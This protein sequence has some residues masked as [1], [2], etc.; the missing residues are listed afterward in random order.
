[1][2]YLSGYGCGFLARLGVVH[3][4]HGRRA[5]PLRVDGR[6]CVRLGLRASR[7]A[8]GSVCGFGILAAMVVAFARAWVWFT[9]FMGGMHG[10]CESTVEDVFV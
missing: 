1:M 4:V 5:R 8:S 2:R 10:H 9:R 3:K 7:R 6:G